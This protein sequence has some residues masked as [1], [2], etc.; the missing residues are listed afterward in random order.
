MVYRRRNGSLM[1]LQQRVRA[2]ASILDIS[3]MLP[4]NALH[5]IPHEAGSHVHTIGLIKA[6]KSRLNSQ[7]SLS[8]LTLSQRPFL[9][10]STTCLSSPA[11]K[12]SILSESDT[13]LRRLA[14][15]LSTPASQFRLPPR[16]LLPRAVARRCAL[17]SSF[18]ATDAFMS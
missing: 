11:T 5:N 17:E 3:L 16:R 13:T 8:S 10:I 15:T 12:R 1:G 18:W 4:R 6:D 7:S 2:K 14:S 9:R